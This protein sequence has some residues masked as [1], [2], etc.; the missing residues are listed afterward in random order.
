MPDLLFIRPEDPDG[1]RWH[2]RRVDADGTSAS[3]AGALADAAPLGAGRR[4]VLLVPGEQVLLTTAR[5]PLRSRARAL[6]AVPWALEDRLVAEV[7]TL[8]FA[9]GPVGDD[10]EWPVA[11]VAHDVLAGCLQAATEAGLS[12]HSAWP[13]PLALPSPESGRWSAL[14]EPGRVVCRTGP[15]SGLACTAS[16]LPGVLHSLE[17]P[18]AIAS[19]RVDGAAADWP[20]S[21]ADKLDVTDVASDPMQAFRSEPA[22]SSI[23]LLQGPYSRSERMGRLWRRWRAP[24]ALAAT[25][26]LLL[27]IH[28]ALGYRQLG[29][30]E[31]ALRAATEEILR[32]AD[33]DVGRIVNPRV[34]LKNR[35][36]AARA[37]NGRTDNGLLA[38]LGR[39]GPVLAEND[40][41]R[42]T[43]LGW[44][45]RQLDLTV[46]ADELPLVDRLQR[47][48][49]AAG[50]EVELRGVK[51]E[52][53]KVRGEVRVTEAAA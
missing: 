15:V 18:A 23:D 31:A 38:L 25:L 49:Q 13:E 33:P 28:T 48:L 42:L 22:T 5:I 51:R 53:D 11:V 41:V 36:D 45:G 52:D 37:A 43:A 21:L 10:G 2:W 44:R 9:L 40:A 7:D 46:E 19:V 39:V 27:A 35:L 17:T 8:H 6:G 3:G 16:M 34:Q 12:P 24:A 47:G 26:V 4:V 1:R 14:E 32:A 29:Q 20:A 30:R 50:L